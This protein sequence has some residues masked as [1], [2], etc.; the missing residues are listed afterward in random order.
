MKTPSPQLSVVIPAH[1]E[2]KSLPTFYEH[3]HGVLQAQKGLTYEIIF[4]DDGS[5]DDTRT[6]LTQF[7]KQNGD[8]RL[9][10]FPRNFGKEAATSAGIQHAHGE[11]I[12]IMDADGQNPP[13]LIPTFL[14]KWH[15]GARVVVGVRT[16]NQ[17]E[18][19]VKRY[20]SKLFYSLLKRMSNG[21]VIPRATD[22]RL[23][24]RTVQQEFNTL[25][26][27]NRMT[28]GL[29]DWLGYDRVIVEFVAK[30][31]MAGEASYKFTKL[32][33]LA[34]SSFVSLTLAPLYAI[35]WTGSIITVLS[36]IAGLFVIT[37]QLIL[38]DPLGFKITGT[39]MLAI[40][41][42]FLIGLVLMSQGLMVLYIS[43]I[44]A[45]TQNRPLYIVD[46]KHSIGLKEPHA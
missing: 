6:L 18:G 17:N 40:L 27:R 41:I 1:N 2:D 37:E 33:K 10:C 12:L 15:D 43:H 22:F 39:A 14:Q 24:D 26:E 31:R 13:E 25:T 36:L 45:E 7:A 16:A 30:P 32:F 44:H 23:I 9:I 42:L 35:A 5:T 8:V 20:G 21:D 3:L 34:I 38:H 28:R 29:I 19:W 11:G 4:V 46:R